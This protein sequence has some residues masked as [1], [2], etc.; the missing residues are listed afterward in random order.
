M[1]YILSIISA[2]ALLIPLA[3]DAYGINCTYATNFTAACSNL[4]FGNCDASRNCGSSDAILND[5]GG[6]DAIVS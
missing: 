2:I 1:K 4:T 5:C 6:L 3:N